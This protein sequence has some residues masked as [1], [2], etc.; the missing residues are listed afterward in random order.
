MFSCQN[1]TV[2]DPKNPGNRLIYDLSFCSSSG[3]ILYLSG[4]NG[5]VKTSVLRA[6]AGLSKPSSGEITFKGK[7]LA[8]FKLKPLHYIGHKLG[9]KQNLSIWD[10]LSFW[11]DSLE[12]REGLQ[13]AIIYLGLQDI[14]E[15]D[16]KLLSFNTCKKVAI[17]RLMLSKAQIWLLDELDTDLDEQ[18]R[19]L[20]SN[21]INIKASSGGIIIS[22]TSDAKEDYQTLNLLDYVK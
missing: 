21:L 15:E 6:I 7:N 13:A 18:D 11:A 3:A 9:I 8:D 16:C 22:T 1:L 19:K 5:I 12:A 10:N 17:A 20:L 2:D 4:A 14:L